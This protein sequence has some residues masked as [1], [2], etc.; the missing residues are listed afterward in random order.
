VDTTNLM[1]LHT[2]PNCSQ[3][4]FYE[5]GTL[6]TNDCDSE[7]INFFAGCSVEDRRTNSAGS[8]FNAI[9][10]GVYAMEWTSYF[11]R[12]WFFP[13]D[14]IP[15]CIHDGKPDPDLFGP[16]LT[17]FETPAANF[18]P[19]DNATCDIDSHFIDHNI[20]INIDFCGDLGSAKY[21]NSTCPQLPNMSPKD[22]CGNFVGSNP[23]AFTD[24]F[25]TINSLKVY[26]QKER[27]P[28]IGPFPHGQEPAINPPGWYHPGM[29]QGGG[30]LA[31]HGSPIIAPTQTA[32]PPS[33]SSQWYRGPNTWTGARN[34]E[35]PS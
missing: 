14:S 2:G 17:R 9:G 12:V 22:S 31:G 4:G 16:S 23:Q 29:G 28:Y 8:G 32:M 19:V 27:I 24:A 5:T 7:P 25:W 1:T 11:I 26:Q 18:M 35:T 15:S 34:Q 20:I 10:G 13:R 3:A 33:L 30:G 21:G 6:I